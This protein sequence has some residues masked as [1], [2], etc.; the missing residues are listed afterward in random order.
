[1]FPLSQCDRVRVFGSKYPRK[2]EDLNDMNL[3]LLTHAQFQMLMSQESLTIAIPPRPYTF[4]RSFAGPATRVGRRTNG[5]PVP[6]IRDTN[7]ENPLKWY[8]DCFHRLY[9][10]TKSPSHECTFFNEKLKLKDLDIDI[11][12]LEKNILDHFGLKD[13]KVFEKYKSGNQDNEIEIGNIQI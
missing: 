1:M 2:R 13:K 9:S 6:L 4:T 11:S 3:A 8:R 5:I 7:F 10:A 12:V